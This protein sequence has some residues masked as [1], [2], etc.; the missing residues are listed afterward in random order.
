M[1][2]SRHLAHKLT[3]GLQFIISGTELGLTK[4]VIEKAREMAK[5]V[6]THVESDEQAQARK[7]HD[8]K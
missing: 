1:V 7:E 5:L 4:Q 2:I 8:T 3:N 6:N